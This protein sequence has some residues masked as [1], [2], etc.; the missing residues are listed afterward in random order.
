MAKN[1]GTKRVVRGWLAAV[2]C[3]W[4][5]F[6]AHAHS[7]PTQASL[8]IMGLITCVSAVIAMAMLGKKFSLL[9]TSVVVLVSQGLYH[10]SLSVMTH[11]QSGA[12]AL[13]G[14]HSGHEHVLSLAPDIAS[15]YAN[16]Q[17][18]SMLY[19]HILAALTS[20]VVLRGG[21][22]LLGLLLGLL[23]LSS[24]RRLLVRARQLVLEVPRVPTGFAT[25]AL[26]KLSVSGRL[27]LRRGPPSV[28][29]SIFA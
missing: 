22:Q 16:V 12:L 8:V 11:H 4:T 28:V 9:A 6:A 29:L 14:G 20:I 15:Q 7:A 25:P 24:A 18:E 23:T 13:T 21:E 17:T 5:A 26:G 3:T 19:A 10:L 2:L 1:L 27:P